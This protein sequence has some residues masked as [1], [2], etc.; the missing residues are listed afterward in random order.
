ML[1]GCEVEGVCA[2]VFVMC[3]CLSLGNALWV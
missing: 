2:C 1:C 3:V